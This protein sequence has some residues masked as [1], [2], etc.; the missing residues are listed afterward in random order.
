MIKVISVKNIRIGEGMP[1]IIVPIADRTRGMIIEK[2]LSFKGMLIDVVEWRVDFYDDVFDTEKVLETVKL[3]RAVIPDMPLLFTFRTKTEGGEKAIS[4]EAYTSLNKA[5]AQSG[6]VDMIDVE[7]FSGDDVVRENIAN[8][9][10]AGVYAVASNHD[11]LKTPVKDELV[12]RLRKMQ[13][14]GAD[15]LKIAMMPTSEAD[16]LTLLSATNE[17]YAKYAEKPII[18]ISMSSKGVISRIA[19][20][21]F[22]SSMTFGSAGQVSAPGQI[23]VEELSAIL[24]ILHEAADS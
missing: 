3:L 14:M 8:I 6:A 13:D 18:T 2:A 4:M 7:I 9:H 22:G 10:E 1:K 20:E 15:I 24:N 21:A 5:V 23:P 11:F 17:M 16:V 19:G 12:S